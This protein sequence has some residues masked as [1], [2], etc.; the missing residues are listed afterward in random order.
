MDQPGN[1]DALAGLG[2][3]AARLQIT[4]DHLPPAFD[5]V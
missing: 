1:M 4:A 5:P 2:A 3:E